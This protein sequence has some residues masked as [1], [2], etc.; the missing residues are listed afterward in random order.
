[1]LSNST[2]PF[3]LFILFHKATDRTSHANDSQ[4]KCKLGLEAA[5]NLCGFFWLHPFENCKGAVAPPLALCSEASLLRASCWQ[6]PAG[7]CWILPGM[8]F[9]FTEKR[10]LI[11]LE[12]AGPGAE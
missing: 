1:M 7:L 8:G 11:A 4:M 10:C 6:P 5:K 9:E 2:R 12:G 3:N